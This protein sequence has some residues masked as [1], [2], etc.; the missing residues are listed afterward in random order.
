MDLTEPR[1]WSRYKIKPISQKFKVFCRFNGRE[2]KVVMLQGENEEWITLEA[3]NWERIMCNKK[4]FEVVWFAKKRK[5]GN[6]ITPQI[7]WNSKI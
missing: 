6:F 2:Y 7:K 5:K 3:Q 4:D 1:V